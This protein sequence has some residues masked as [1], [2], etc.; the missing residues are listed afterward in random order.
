M[1]GIK[2]FLFSTR[3]QTNFTWFFEN[4]SPVPN[5]KITQFLLPIILQNGID[6]TQQI[7]RSITWISNELQTQLKSKMM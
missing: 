1:L 6:Y 2:E 3:S 4:T 5:M 7:P